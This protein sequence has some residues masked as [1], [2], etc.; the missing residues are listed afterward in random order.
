[1][2]AIALI[3]GLISLGTLCRA[4]FALAVHA[5][6][7]FVAASVAL[8]RLNAGT[9]LRG[10][11]LF[12]LL[13]AALTVVGGRVVFALAPSVTVRVTI[14]A[15][16]LVPAA[17]AGYYAAVGLSWFAGPSSFWQAVA[18]WAGAILVCAAAWRKLA[19]FDDHGSARRRAE[20]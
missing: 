16:F 19:S 4:M 7:F 3:L 14:A 18:G 11:L 5:L 17:I 9:D 20:P 12:G 10:A 15:A 2:L 6:P 13:A 1:M 8:A